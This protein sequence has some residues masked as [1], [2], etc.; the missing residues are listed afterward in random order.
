MKPEHPLDRA[1]RLREDYL[2]YLE[3]ALP[4]DPTQRRLGEL[5]REQIQQVGGFVTEPLF[6]VNPRFRTD[7]SMKQLVDEGV[8]GQAMLT[9]NPDRFPPDR[10]LY[11]HQTSAIRRV[12]QRENVVVATGTGSGKTECFLLPVLDDA[13]RHP[14]H[15][16]RTLL[17]YPMNALANDQLLR[18]RQIVG[19]S[20]I[21][22]GRYTGETPKTPDDLEPLPPQETCPS[23]LRSREEIRET[24]PQILLTNFAMLEYL[25]L[26][27]NDQAIFA[28]DCLTTVVLDEAHAYD[29]VQG[30]DVGMLMRRLQQR[31][32]RNLQFILTSATLGDEGP[33]GDSTVCTFAQRLT[34]GSFTSGNV[35]R[36]TAVPITD[37]AAPKTDFTAAMNQAADP[38]DFAAACQRAGQNDPATALRHDPLTAWIFEL[39]TQKPRSLTQLAEATGERESRIKNRLRLALSDQLA[40]AGLP[41]VRMHQFFRGL[42]GA[43]VSLTV[44]SANDDQ[45]RPPADAC[46]RA[47][48]LEEMV[49]EVTEETAW[50]PLVCCSACGFPAIEAELTETQNRCRPRTLR[51]PPDRLRL[52]TWVDADGWA[53]D[54]DSEEEA[55]A[56][57][58][59]W[60]GTR[61]GRYH[62]DQP[63]TSAE[64]VPLTRL[65]TDAQGHVPTCRRCRASAKPF[66][67]IFRSFRT[68]ED[69][70]TAVLA[71]AMLLALPE[72]QP[73]RPAGGRQLLAFSDSRQKAAYFAPYLNRTVRDVAEVQPLVEAA[74]QLDQQGSGAAAE[75]VVERAVEIARSRPFVVIPS[76]EGIQK[77]VA[78]EELGRA[79]Q[80]KLAVLLSKV[81]LRHL[82][83]RPRQRLRLPA[84]GLA[85]PGFEISEAERTH[86]D[87]L[88][89]DEVPDPTS[90]ADL[91]QATLLVMLQRQAVTLPHGLTL[92]DVLYLDQGPQAAG[93]HLSQSASS[94][95]VT[96]V[97]FNPFEAPRRSRKQAM[98]HS[99]TLALV[100]ALVG[101]HDDDRLSHLLA[102]LWD[103]LRRPGAGE[104][105]LLLPMPTPGVYRINRDRLLVHTTGP[106]HLC[107]RCG[108]VTR[109]PLGSQCLLQSCGGELEAVVP[110]DLTRGR[111]S[112]LGQ[113]YAREP[114]LAD[115][116]EHTAQLT[117][118]RG[119][120]VQQQFLEGKINVLSCSTTFEMGIDVGD[121]DAVLLRNV[122]PTPANYVQR[123]GR[124]GRRNQSV[125]HA[126]VY[127][128]ARPHDQH[129]YHLPAEV[130][131]GRVDVPRVHL[132]NR[133]LFQRHVNSYLLGRFWQDSDMPATVQVI[134]EPDEDRCGFLPA[135]AEAADTYAHRFCRWLDKH[136][137]TLT[138]N[139]RA[140]APAKLKNDAESFSR[141]AGRGLLPVTAM[142]MDEE[143]DGTRNIC[144][145]SVWR[146]L[147]AWRDQQK[148]LQ[149]QI[150]ERVSAGQYNRVAPLA[151]AAEMIDRLIQQYQRGRLLDLLSFEH[152]LPNFAFPQD[153]TRLRV[154]S[155]GHSNDLR[156]ERPRS[157]AIAEYAPGAEI[158]VNGQSITAHGL[159]LL[160]REPDLKKFRLDKERQIVE[161]L[162]TS[163]QDQR[164]KRCEKLVFQPDGFVTEYGKPPHEPNVF[165]DPP[166][167][168]T[169]AYLVRGSE[170]QNFRPVASLPKIHTAIKQ[171]ARVVR[172][173][174]GN[175]QGDRGFRICMR[176]GVSPAVGDHT[177]P[178]GAKCTGFFRNVVLM[179]E[180]RSDVLQIRFDAFP[181]EYAADASHWQTLNAA[182]ARTACRFLTIRHGDIQCGFRSRPE[183]PEQ[184][185]MFLYDT[186][187]GGAGYV[188]T[189]DEHLAEVL[190]ATADSLAHCVNDACSLESSCYACLRSQDNQ[191]SWPQLRREDG[192]A[193]LGAMGVKAALH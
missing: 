32:Q 146:R 99:R 168:V 45:P 17:I 152:W 7:V 161:D 76:D 100:R 124:A 13:L 96:V 164:L 63:P 110:E 169:P 43:A 153:T 147:A 101:E 25:L 59:V 52:L 104:N 6:S 30:I 88:M 28:E 27:P 24:P 190:Q 162:G 90:R 159:D 42:H 29:G 185:E 106:W 62:V 39:L 75:S 119:R 21:R 170:P 85:F 14:G 51:T 138:S 53:D 181:A 172:L 89:S 105:A 109:Y 8:L 139:I 125:A 107:R 132:D 66:P 4:I 193:A 87:E 160:N 142:G 60:L 103:A 23:E 117:H 2:A 91:L 61:D 179:D 22:F 173:N 186:V 176:C 113:R 171:R 67:S 92:R 112:R 108:A 155:E 120:E 31:T 16:V 158:I 144:E 46:I 131:A 191:F 95:G 140:F 167:R 143:P 3:D 12:A 111:A 134:D 175:T 34:G 187:P 82:C 192:L 177:T 157:R 150:Q 10:P 123:V 78:R 156:L 141:Q 54:A 184:G 58:R 165:R 69:A 26:R 154:V 73:Q 18:L 121:L 114:M 115:A 93:F 44:P 122:P 55:E 116:A 38:A 72:Q 77:L 163:V 178:W 86:Y 84:L 81:L 118:K 83:S 64:A 182:V 189:I 9:L 36:G 151:K 145:S 47:V 98:R 56:A 97:R 41:A 33:E 102:S 128:P 135:S 129:F 37:P 174:L 50:W 35:V 80:S 19:D 180:L 148:E 188:A 74:R 20:G 70:P 126:V 183:S 166:Q 137:E 130:A 136:G 48:R 11:A 149:D 68:G 49:G 65:D 5:Y 15:G 79:Q 71:E 94:D 133:V 57:D 127:A 1:D 40:D